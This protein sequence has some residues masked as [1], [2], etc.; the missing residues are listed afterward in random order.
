MRS[1]IKDALL[2]LVIRSSMPWRPPQRSWAF[3]PMLGVLSRARPLDSDA[4]VFVD[5]PMV[6]SM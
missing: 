4:G 6:S 5:I 2:V 1:S 3:T